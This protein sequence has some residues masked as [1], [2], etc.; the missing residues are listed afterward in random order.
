VVDNEVVVKIH[1]TGKGIRAEDLPRLFEPFFTTKGGERTG[2]GLSGSLGIAKGHGG[3]ISIRSQEGQGATVTVRLP[4]AHPSGASGAV[5]DPDAR[6]A[7]G[8]ALLIIDDL[9][10][11]AHMLGQGLES[12]GY[13]VFLADSG[14]KGLEIVEKSDIDVIICDLSMPEMD[15]RQTAR[16]MADYH[17]SKGL[18]RP[19][20]I[21][22]TGFTESLDESELMGDGLMDSFIEKPV[23]TLVLSGLIQEVLQRKDSD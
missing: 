5:E 7:G 17:H 2:M 23:D 14:K 15:G 4:R 19:K 8:G 22:L 12:Q 3:D 6:A 9:A 21:L 16:A 1:D 20:F 11:L 18:N 13:T 10:P